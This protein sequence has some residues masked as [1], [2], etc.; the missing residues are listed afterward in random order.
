MELIEEYADIMR[1][2]KMN[3]GTAYEFA[4]AI[5]FPD[6][7]AKTFTQTNRYIDYWVTKQKELVDRKCKGLDAYRGLG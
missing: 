5:G 2:A 3:E 1:A 4:A 7:G 6:V